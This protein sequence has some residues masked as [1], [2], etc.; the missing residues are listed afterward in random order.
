MPQGKREGGLV[1]VG[2]I[3]GAH[4][5]RGGVKLLYYSH[6]KAFPYSHITLQE[7]GGTRRRFRVLSHRP[8]KGTLALQLEG[9]HTR[10]EAQALTGRVAYCPR[11]EFPR[12]APDEFYWIDLIGMTVTQISRPGE[13]RLSGLLET[14]G[15]DVLEIAWGER[16]YLVPFS[17][18]WIEEISLH[19]RRL[20]LKEGTL[21]FFDVH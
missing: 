7:N 2:K 13:G 21:E 15:T 18:H 19:E 10:T 5:I 8:L 11:G 14:G 12:V 20:V 4:G 6:L 9:I 3:V 1:P 16:E 17:Y